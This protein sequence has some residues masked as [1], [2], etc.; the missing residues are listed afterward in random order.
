MPVLSIPVVFIEGAGP[1]TLT[2]PRWCRRFVHAGYEPVDP[3]DYPAVPAR[4]IAR[5]GKPT[6][7][8]SADQYAQLID[9]LPTLPIL[10]GFSSGALVAQKLLAYGLGIAAVAIDAARIPVSTIGQNNSPAG[11][12]SASAPACVPDVSGPLLFLHDGSDHTVGNGSAVSAFEH[13]R[14]PGSVTEIHRIP[15]HDEF[16]GHKGRSVDLAAAALAWLSY[17]A[18]RADKLVLR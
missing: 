8:D 11:R 4:P 14:R 5:H 9:R 2:H 16:G 1:Q 10:V 17:H 13:L 3:R 15:Q 6:A 7:P 18:V 12:H